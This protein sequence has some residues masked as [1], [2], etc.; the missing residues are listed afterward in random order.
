MAEQAERRRLADR[1]LLKLGG[2]PFIPCPG[3]RADGTPCKGRHTCPAHAEGPRCTGT[4]ADGKPCTRAARDGT[5]TCP[6]HAPGAADTRAKKRQEKK[7]EVAAMPREDSEA[8]VRRREEDK[9]RAALKRLG[10]PVPI[11]NA[12]VELQKVAAEVIA[13]KDFLRVKLFDID[14]ADWRFTSA[15]NLEQVHGI[16][17]LFERALDRT[18]ITLTSLSRVQADDRL[19]AI[20][21]AKLAMVL[22]ALRGAL[23]EAGLDATVA[24]IIK[25]AFSRRIRV[26]RT[27]RIRSFSSL[28]DPTSTMDAGFSAGVSPT[29]TRPGRHGSVMLRPK[30]VVIILRT[31]TIGFALAFAPRSQPRALQPLR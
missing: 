29:R 21:E 3:T 23:T 15:Q 26:I 8:T 19:A 6:V 24:E 31:S 22:A 11:E 10:E 13:F 25:Q 30:P 7:K 16:A 2:K 28:N 5:G 20:E 18:I 9:A 1:P 14:V 12:L 27:E 17:Q 4:R